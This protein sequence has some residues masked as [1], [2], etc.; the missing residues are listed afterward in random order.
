MPLIECT[1]G[2]AETTIAGHMYI[3]SRDD[4]GRY[5]ALVE[6]P[7]HLH[8]LLSVVHYRIAPPRGAKSE[9]AP[10]SPKPAA[11]ATHQTGAPQPPAG[12]AMAGRGGGGSGD[13]VSVVTVTI[14][15]S[16]PNARDAPGAEAQTG[17]PDGPAA[18]GTASQTDM[19]KPVSRRGR[20][21]KAA[22]SGADG[23]APGG[24]ADA[25]GPTPQP[26]G[27]ATGDAGELK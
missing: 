17:I 11:P 3:F 18:T 5:V 7:A 2:Y 26:T 23:A 1:A 16:E 6:N 13:N 8:C 4:E 24:G 15:G 10:S 21:P 25:A 20:K 19:P 9:P 12:E 14:G 22:A 27:A